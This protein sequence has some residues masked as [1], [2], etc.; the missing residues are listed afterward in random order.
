MK[1]ALGLS[2]I[3]MLFCFNIGM[4]VIDTTGLY[5]DTEIDYEASGVYD[6]TT[7][8]N[9]QEDFNS[10]QLL[11]TIG[12][13][14]S[15]GVVGAILGKLAGVDPLRSGVI[16]SFVTFMFTMFA[17]TYSVLINFASD[18]GG[19]IAETIVTIFMVVQIIFIVIFIYQI[20]TGGW[21]S[22]I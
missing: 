21:Q 11:I 13:V 16:S 6:P 14:G 3:I 12:I 17:S 2:I 8:Y 15:L 19:G 18:I 4:F 1:N 22:T 20:A 7:E 5:A 9:I 10:A